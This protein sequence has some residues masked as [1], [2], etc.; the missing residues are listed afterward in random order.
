MKTADSDSP[1]GPEPPVAV[2]LA[3]GA[4]LRLR[5]GGSETPKPLMR[6]AGLSLAERC[7]CGLLGAGI[8]RF[9]VILG[10]QAERVRSHFEEIGERRGCEIAFEVAEQWSLGNGSSALAARARVGDRPFLLTMVDHLLSAPMIEAILTAPPRPNEIALAV[11][12]RKEEVFDPA[13]S[14]FEKAS[15]VG[16]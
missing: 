7:V 13:V 10:H 15:L 16:F 9:V 8:R 4:G 11:D 14:Q 12:G 2:V 5:D 1:I 3:A 6:L